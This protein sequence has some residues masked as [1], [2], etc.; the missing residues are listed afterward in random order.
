MK[1][2]RTSTVSVPPTCGRPPP[3]QIQW[4]R[5]L[6]EQNSIRAWWCKGRKFKRPIFLTK[7]KDHGL[8]PPMSPIPIH[9]DAHLTWLKNSVSHGD[10]WVWVVGW[11]W[12]GK[13]CSPVW[14]KQH[15]HFH[16]C[17]LTHRLWWLDRFNCVSPH[18]VWIM[19]SE[20]RTD[21]V[22]MSNGHLGDR[23]V[24]LNTAN[25]HR[26]KLC[27]W[28][29]FCCTNQLCGGFQ[30]GHRCLLWMSAPM[31]PVLWLTP[32]RHTLTLNF[33]LGQSTWTWPKK[34]IPCFWHHQFCCRP[35]VCTNLQ[36]LSL[37][38]HT[39]KARN[40]DQIRLILLQLLSHESLVCQWLQLSLR[41][42]SSWQP[43]LPQKLTC[44][45]KV[46]MLCKVCHSMTNDQFFFCHIWKTFC[47]WR[48]LQVRE[49]SHCCQ[50][51][52]EHARAAAHC[53]PCM[54][55]FDPKIFTKTFVYGF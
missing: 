14:R 6:F 21:R 35:F 20:G 12:N 36:L 24:A 11:N 31:T 13:P 49:W 55:S 47:S 8:M 10:S 23:C 39:S 46:S 53:L 34:M 7:F 30:W 37:H 54:F 51:C 25:S 1:R 44:R 28:A 45:K 9:K 43:H 50:E 5:F 33:S 40:N 2:V 3:R 4:R 22:D 26:Q 48:W 41:K 17:V 32:T 19:L 29:L 27:I 42:R 18:M 52:G 16:S 38:C 15:W